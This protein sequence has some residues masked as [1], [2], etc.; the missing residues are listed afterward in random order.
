MPSEFEKLSNRQIF[1]RN[2]RWFL[3]GLGFTLLGLWVATHLFG[4]FPFPDP[5]NGKLPPQEQQMWT[6]AE[7]GASLLSWTPWGGVATLAVT[8]AHQM[9]ENY[10]HK[11]ALGVVTG[12]MEEAL[13]LLPAAQR[14]PLIA[15]MKDKQDTAGVRK[16]IQKVRGKA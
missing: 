5:V 13:N 2:V 12:S 7:F 1:R 9:R 16:R 6:W 10:V 14:D 4:C 8:T 3:I 11:K 15:D